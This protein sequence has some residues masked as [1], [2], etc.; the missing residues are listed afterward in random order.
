MEKNEDSSDSERGTF[1]DLAFQK[2]VVR[3]GILMQSYF[4]G[5]G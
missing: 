3:S 4:L 2:L 5:S 1:V